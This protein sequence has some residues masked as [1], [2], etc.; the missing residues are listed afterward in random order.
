MK[1]VKTFFGIAWAT[2]LL[3]GFSYSTWFLWK[4]DHG[5]I[6]ENIQNFV[7]L[8]PYWSSLFF[9]FF[10]SIR[11]VIYF[12][13]FPVLVFFGIFFGPVWGT[14]L[15]VSGAL[16]SAVIM[17]AIA[18]YFGHQFIIKHEHHLLKRIDIT[19]EHKGFLTVFLLR[20]FFFVPMD[21]VSIAAGI[22]RISFLDYVLASIIG[23][24]PE[25][26]FYT[27]IG[28][29]FSNPKALYYVLIMAAVMIPLF[30]WAK[31]HP[32]FEHLFDKRIKIPF[33]IRR[34]KK[35]K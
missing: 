13:I 34:K 18:R 8:H 10:F 27:I 16:L 25:V 28:G 21:L 14:V 26:L 12:P 7:E 3:V 35:K 17:F 2:L 33:P 32:H 20:V 23:F 4:N 29:S 19:L 5:V 11:T 15:G 9:M 31:K 24:I 30:F 6:I 22:S 1:K